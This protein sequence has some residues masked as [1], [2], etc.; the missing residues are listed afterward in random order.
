MKIATDIF[1]GYGFVAAERVITWWAMISIKG[2]PHQMK[3]SIVI[4]TSSTCNNENR[5]GHFLR[6]QLKKVLTWWVTVPTRGLPNHV[7]LWI[8]AFTCFTCKIRR[9]SRTCTL[10]AAEESAHIVGHGTSK[11]PAKPC[12]AIDSSFHKFRMG[13]YTFD[14]FQA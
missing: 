2:L 11:G 4:L 9:P 7:K 1:Y 12:E 14:P 3:L 13:Y 5:Y 8:V 6:G 10:V